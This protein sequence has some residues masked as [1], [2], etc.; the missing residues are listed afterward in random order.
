MRPRLIDRIYKPLLDPGRMP[1]TFRHFEQERG[2]GH[3]VAL[4]RR[5][6]ARPDVSGDRSTLR[7]RGFEHLSV[8]SPER[9]RATSS[10]L[11]G[12][13]PTSVKKGSAKLLGYRLDGDHRRDL[14]DAV[15]T[16]AVDERI[17]ACFASEYLV[18]WIS[19][20]VTLPDPGN[21][22]VSFRWH[23]DK[24]P[25]EHLK[26]IVYLNGTREH[27]GNT[28]FVDRADTAR[29]GS[30]GY[31][32]GRTRSRTSEVEKL[33]RIAGQPVTPHQQPLEPGDAVLFQPAR[34]LHRGV[35]PSRAPRHTL[36]LCLLPSPVPWREALDQGTMVDLSR[37]AKWPGH[38]REL[39]A[40]L[41]IESADPLP[42]PG[43]PS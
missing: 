41:G 11:A 28:E 34:V 25:A 29:V 32:F 2:F 37:D 8:L 38:A 12:T 14:L 13:A 23:C 6:F 35:L 36:T 20:T 16:P 10:R 9:A 15:L 27:G 3:Y 43:V 31:V 39:L 4:C 18:H 22:T 30:R 7:T 1:R 33:S 19:A 42:Q 40:K 17:A 21:A 24:G 26:L 5:R